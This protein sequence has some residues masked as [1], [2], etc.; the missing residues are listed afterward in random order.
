MRDTGKITTFPDA[1]HIQEMYSKLQI[2]CSDDT[3]CTH[4]MSCM[5]FQYC[6]GPISS[7]VSWY[8]TNDISCS[9]PYA[10]GHMICNVSF[11]NYQTDGL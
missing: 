6:T 7:I 10:T 5:N 1:G 4:D 3:H 11:H 9:C 2:Y 8:R